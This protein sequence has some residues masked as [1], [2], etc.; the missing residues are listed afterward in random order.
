MRIFYFFRE[1]FSPIVPFAQT[2]QRCIVVIML[3]FIYL[4]SPFT[5]IAA[6]SPRNFF[7]N[8][9]KTTLNSQF[10]APVFF[11][12]KFSQFTDGCSPLCFHILSYHRLYLSFFLVKSSLFSQPASQLLLDFLR[13]ISYVW[14]KL[15]LR[16]TF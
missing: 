7:P 10:S 14:K 5:G 6:I 4:I 11:R 3:C 2:I 16:T 13:A 8:C 15:A 12:E 9:V 1:N